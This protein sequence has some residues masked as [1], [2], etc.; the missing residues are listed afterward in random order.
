[1]G[2]RSKKRKKGRISKAKRNYIERAGY[3]NH[4]HM[5]N[6]TNGGDRHHS[7]MLRL[8]ERRHSAFHLLFINRDFLQAAKVLIRTH[9]LK[10]GTHYKIVE[11]DNVVD[12]NVYCNC[13]A[14]SGGD[15]Y[16]NM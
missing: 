7:N 2:K 13:S 10:K 8:D 11:V 1:M 16:G 12:N 3:S 6:R 14:C 5:L 15:D 4:H 9:N